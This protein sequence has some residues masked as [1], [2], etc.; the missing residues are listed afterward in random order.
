MKTLPSIAVLL[1]ANGP[2]KWFVALQNGGESRGTGGL[3]GSFAVV[4]LDKGK[5]KAQ[6]DSARTNC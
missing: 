3:L 5:A 4:D 1:G 2:Q 6:T